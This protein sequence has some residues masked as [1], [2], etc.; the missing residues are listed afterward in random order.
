MFFFFGFRFLTHPGLCGM[1]V[2]FCVCLLFL[3]CAFGTGRIW[4]LES[5]IRDD[6]FEMTG[7]RA[8]E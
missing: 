2:C 7:S 5:G 4:H 3:R 8:A 6:G 1:Y